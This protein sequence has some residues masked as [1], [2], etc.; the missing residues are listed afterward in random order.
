VTYSIENNELT[1][2]Q[3]YHGIFG[4]APKNKDENKTKAKKTELTE[5]E[6]QE[7]CSVVNGERT[8]F[9]DNWIT[10]YNRAKLLKEV[11][12]HEYPAKGLSDSEKR[13]I[14][15]WLPL[16]KLLLE[17]VTVSN[18]DFYFD[19]QRRLSG[20]QIVRVKMVT[21]L[22]EQANRS[23]SMAILAEEDN[24][25][26]DAQQRNLKAR[27]KTLAQEGHNWI[28]VNGNQISISFPATREEYLETKNKTASYTSKGT[29][30]IEVS[31]GDGITTIAIGH[32]GADPVVISKQMQGPY[33]TNAV[34]HIA[35]EYG[36][37]E[38]LDIS[39]LKQ[40]IFE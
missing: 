2:F 3:E 18:G 30:A 35:T 28:E 37:K 24:P 33:T 20:Y 25:N 21:Q 13:Y 5:E 32:S 10:E 31:Y 22:I 12:R 39:R 17:N 9:F 29:Q 26:A 14:R 36:I 27:Q 16:S 38:Q 40:A 19:D 15:D 34:N 1:L 8:F 7:I 4:E 23:I 6:K 11:T